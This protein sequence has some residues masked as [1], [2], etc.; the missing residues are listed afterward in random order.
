MGGPHF[1]QHVESNSGFI[2]PDLDVFIRTPVD[3][4]YTTQVAKRCYQLPPRWYPSLI[5]TGLLLVQLAFLTLVLLTFGRRPGLMDLGV[6]RAVLCCI[7]WLL[8]DTRQM[9]S[10][11]SKSSSCSPKFHWIPLRRSVI[12]SFII[13]SIVSRNK[14]SAIKQPCLTPVLTVRLS[15]SPPAEG[16][17]KSSSRRSF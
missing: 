17:S 2:Y 1:P 4:D 5:V 8:L 14:N 3:A 16:L 11:N 10:A 12:V 7:C 13:Q 6:S 9:S 15:D